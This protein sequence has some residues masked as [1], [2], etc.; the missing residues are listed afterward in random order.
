MYG[1]RDC[2]AGFSSRTAAGSPP[3]RTGI[4]TFVT[5]VVADLCG[6]FG[7]G[8]TVAAWRTLG[9]AGVVRRAS[10]GAVADI[11]DYAVFCGR[12]RT[13]VS[14]GLTSALLAKGI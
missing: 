1:R 3:C 9:G 14:A 12:W 6:I 7:G 8:E 2:V 13:S 11:A 10:L 5:G 4:S